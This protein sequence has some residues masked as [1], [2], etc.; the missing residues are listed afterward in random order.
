MGYVVAARHLQL[1]QLVAMKFLRRNSAGL[2]ETEATGRFLREAKAV[3]RLRDEHIAKVFDVGTLETRRAVHRDGVP[4]R[5]R[6]RRAREAARTAPRVRGRRVRDA[7]VRGARR[8]AQHRHRASRREAREPLRHAWPR[9]LASREGPRLRHLEGQSVRRDGGGARDDAHVVD[10]RQPALHVARADAR[11]AQGRRAKRPLVARRRAL[12][13]RRG[14]AAVR[15]RDARSP[16]LDGHAREPG[17]ALGEPA[18]ISRRASRRPCTT[19][20]RR[21]R[22]FASRTSPSSP[23]R[24]LRTRSIPVRAR[25]VADRV[26]QTLS[27]A[28]MPRTLEIAAVLAAPAR[29][30]RDHDVGQGLEPAGRER[31]RHRGAVGRHARRSSARLGTRRSHLGRGRAPRDARRRRACS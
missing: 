30:T 4:R 12:P 24:S 28:Q 22:T 8:G 15:G 25:G 11:P 16:A 29:T 31:H 1:D 14:Q 5:L 7:G 27:V 6:P 3:V 20:S 23:T 13:P 17:P 19:A 10:A 9:G 18:P 26:A 21:I 2:D